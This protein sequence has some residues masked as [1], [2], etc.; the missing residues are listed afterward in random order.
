MILLDPEARPVIAH[1]GA[2]GQYP[3]NTLLA[4]A[5]ALEQGADAIELDVRVTADGVPVVLHDPTLERTTTGAGAVSRLSLTEV[6]R[7]DAGT[8]ER[9]PTLAEVLDGFPTAPL[10][11]EI[12]ERRAARATLALLREHH[13]ERRVLVGAFHRGELAPFFH[14]EFARSP[15]RAEV[16]WFWAG[17]RVGLTPGGVGYRAF[18]VPEYSGR[19]RVVDDVFVAAARR[20]RLPVHVWTVDDAD[21]AARLRALGVCGIITGFPERMRRLGRHNDHHGIRA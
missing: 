14:T 20:R 21:R 6:R 9:V 19:L 2:S 7:A 1:R 5:K 17:S 10:L 4:F 13:A 12:K 18:S 16:A 15:V 8:G 3:E 11:V